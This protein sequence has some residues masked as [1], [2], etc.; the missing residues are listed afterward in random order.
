[1]SVYSDERP[2]DYPGSSQGETFLGEPGEVVGDHEEEDRIA[3]EEW[4]GEQRAADGLCPHRVT[5]YVWCGEYFG[6]VMA[7]CSEHE[8]Q[9][10]LDYPQ[11]WQ[12]YPGDVCPHGKYT[13]GCGIDWMCGPCEMGEE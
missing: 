7:L 12:S 6:G 1:M 8:A 4:R 11:G 13:G 2:F 5:R 10:K 3:Y 9:A